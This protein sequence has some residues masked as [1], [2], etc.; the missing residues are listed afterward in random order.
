M[1]L[2]GSSFPSQGVV[3]LVLSALVIF[4]HALVTQELQQ[5][6]H[7]SVKSYQSPS[8]LETERLSNTPALQLRP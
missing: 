3:L 1:M 7:R 8:V 5:Y 4:R 6:R 2:W